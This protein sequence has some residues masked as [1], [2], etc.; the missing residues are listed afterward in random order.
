MKVSGGA[1]PAEMDELVARARRG[2]RAALEA[3]LAAVAPAV[4]RFGLRM[5]KNVH[6]AEDVLQDTLLNIANH[7]GDFEGRSSLSSW[8]FALTR[9][10]CTRKR[11]GLKNQPT[12]GD[13][14]I[15]DTPDVA[16]S[17][18][19]HTADH[20]LASALSAALNAL[21]VDYRE[22]ILLRDVEGLSAPEA[23]SSI[24]ISVDALK[25]RLHRARDA[26]RTALRPVFE[27]VRQQTRSGCPD[28]AALWS[29]K[30]E[31]DLSVLDCSAMEQHLAG[32]A[33]CGAAADAL[34]RA[35]LACQSVRTEPVP[36]AVQERVKAAVRAWSAPGSSPR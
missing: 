11:R 10:A 24:G 5:C 9:S 23:A 36:P 13:E 6:D 18:E 26:L 33:V 30:L 29:Q 31:G 12:F 35:L 7:L 3:V 22:V 19:T 28:V 4:H 2:E 27:P 25:S 34:R 21:P 20:E 15:A 32:C 16:P 14:R 1:S 17:P 8:V